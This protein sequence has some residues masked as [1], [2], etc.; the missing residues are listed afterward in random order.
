MVGLL[1]CNA[2]LQQPVAMPLSQERQAGLGSVVRHSS[3]HALDCQLPCSSAAYI[4]EQR[5]RKC[6]AGLTGG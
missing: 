3:M 5:G 1:T 2:Q 6:W 4:G